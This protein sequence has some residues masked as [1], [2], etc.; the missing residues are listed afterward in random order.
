M[1]IVHRRFGETTSIEFATTDE[2]TLTSGTAAKGAWVE[3][4]TATTLHVNYLVIL[5]DDA[6]TTNIYDTDIGTGA[7]GSE[8]VLIPNIHFHINITGNRIIPIIYPFKADLAQGT[9][10]SARTQAVANTDTLRV[11][12]HCT[13]F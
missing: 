3:L 11:V 1:P 6:N 8:V 5:M 4:S 2:V 9:R 7:A 12:I 10:L 13:G